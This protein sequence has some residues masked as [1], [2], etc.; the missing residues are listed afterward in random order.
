MALQELAIPG[1]SFTLLPDDQGTTPSAPPGFPLPIYQ[2]L[3]NNITVG[4][5]QFLSDVVD[6]IFQKMLPDFTDSQILGKE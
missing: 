5:M 3:H 6:P 2:E 4:A 1:Q